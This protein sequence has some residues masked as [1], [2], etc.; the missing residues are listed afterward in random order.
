MSASLH[1]LLVKIRIES[2]L[3][4][5]HT[6]EQSGLTTSRRPHSTHSVL[7]LAQGWVYIF[8]DA[9]AQKIEQVIY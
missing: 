4:S 3:T 2:E 6:D 5:S 8:G 9:V 1:Q 7:C